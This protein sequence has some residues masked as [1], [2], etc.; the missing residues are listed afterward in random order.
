MTKNYDDDYL[1]EIQANMN[2]DVFKT[3]LEVMCQR[4]MEDELARHVGAS[5]HERGP[6]RVGHR[7][8]HKGTSIN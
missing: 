7:N 2:G 1:D 8:G 6:D 3:M 5:R 4:V